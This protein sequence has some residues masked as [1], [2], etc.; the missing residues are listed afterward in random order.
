MAAASI[1]SEAGVADVHMLDDAG[2]PVP[3]DSLLLEVARRPLSLV[4]GEQ[5]LPV[6]ACKGTVGHASADEHRVHLQVL[7]RK[8][9]Y[10]RVRK[11]LESD[12]RRQIKFSVRPKQRRG[13][14]SPSW[15][16]VALT[17]SHLLSH[18]RSS[19]TFAR[20]T[21]SPLKRRLSC[22]A[23]CMMWAS[24]STFPMYT[25]Q[26]AALSLGFICLLVLQ[27]PGL[28]SCCC[29]S[30]ASFFQSKLVD[31]KETV[32]LKPEE[33]TDSV[34]AEF[35]LTSPTQ[36]FVSEQVTVSLWWLSVHNKLT[37][38]CAALAHTQPLY[39]LP[40][41]QEASSAGGHVTG[42]GNTAVPQDVTR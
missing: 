33:V 7:M 39:T 10:M 21:A 2:D 34:F 3:T 28:T 6:S 4:I 37:C 24:F 5:Q 25:L 38:H 19:W 1:A 36:L 15:G 35:G 12:T 32:F 29:C 8:A 11:I 40:V 30:S 17:R 31:I 9:N 41:P 22:A 42:A 20:P 18:N 14:H 23:S 16:F 13:D 26:R 27:S